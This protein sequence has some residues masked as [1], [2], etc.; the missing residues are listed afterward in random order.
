[1]LVKNIKCCEYGSRRV[2]HST[3]SN[4]LDRIR[5]FSNEQG[6]LFC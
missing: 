6:I 1:M 2:S 4:W 3:L 5:L